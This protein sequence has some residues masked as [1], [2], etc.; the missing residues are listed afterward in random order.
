[1]KRLVFGAVCCI[2]GVVWLMFANQA[3]KDNHSNIIPPGLLIII[4]II[5]VVSDVRS[6]SRIK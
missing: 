5:L 1:M 2:V 6:T 4:G 3:I